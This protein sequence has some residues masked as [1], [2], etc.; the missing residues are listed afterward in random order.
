MH[1]VQVNLITEANARFQ[2]RTEAG[3]RPMYSGAVVDTAIGQVRVYGDHLTS[4]PRNFG[5][6]V[7]HTWRLNGKV[8]SAAKLEQAL[9]S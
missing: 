8:I 2:S 5:K 4:N 9:T 7:R 1:Q 6:H 3:E